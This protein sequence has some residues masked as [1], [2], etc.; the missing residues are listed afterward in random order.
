MAYKKT[1]NKVATYGEQS[2]SVM[3]LQKQLNAKGAGLS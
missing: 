2:D 1:N 3:E